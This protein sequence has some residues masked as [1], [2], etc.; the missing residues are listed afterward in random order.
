MTDRADLPWRRPQEADFCE[1]KRTAARLALRDL[2]VIAAVRSPELQLKC[3]DRPNS[4]S[5]VGFDQAARF[6]DL[7]DPGAKLAREDRWPI[8]P[9]HHLR[10]SVGSIAIGAI[11]PRQRRIKWCKSPSRMIG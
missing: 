2:E 3:A 1:V 10:R 6:A 8:G 7:D 11:V 4:Q 5:P 9:V